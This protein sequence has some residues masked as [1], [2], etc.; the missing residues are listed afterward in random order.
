MSTNSARPPLSIGDTRRWLTFHQTGNAR[1]HNEYWY[2]TDIWRSRPAMPAVA[3]E[4]YYPGDHFRPG[5][6]SPEYAEGGTE[7][8][9]LYNRSS[10]YGNFLSG[11]FGGHIQGSDGIWQASIEPEARV[12]MWD[13]SGWNPERK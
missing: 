11:G 12:K 7:R 13:A 2:M 9:S 1:P 6:F 4:P 3:G 8:D 10:M 5:E